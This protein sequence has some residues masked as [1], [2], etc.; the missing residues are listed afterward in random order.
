MQAQLK[1]EQVVVDNKKAE[2]DA[3]LVQVGGLRVRLGL[4]LD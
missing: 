4:G 3:L 1:D 2:T